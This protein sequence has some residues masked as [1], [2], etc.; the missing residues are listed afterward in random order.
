[1][2]MA[3]RDLEACVLGVLGEIIVKSHGLQLTEN[4]GYLDQHSMSQA[5]HG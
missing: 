5:E 3:S 4:K 2:L 1:M